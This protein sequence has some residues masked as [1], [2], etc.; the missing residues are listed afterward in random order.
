MQGNRA[1]N[2]ET[3]W[4]RSAA[5]A[6]AGARVPN[7]RVAQPVR[8]AIDAPNLRAAIDFLRKAFRSDM[9]TQASDVPTAAKGLGRWRPGRYL[10]SCGITS[11]LFLILASISLAVILAMS[12]SARISFARG[13]IGY[14]NEQGLARIDSLA[15]ELAIEFAKHGGWEFL[16]GRPRAW[17][18]LLRPPRPAAPPT[19][20]TP[21]PPLPEAE[22]IGVTQRLALLDVQKRYVIGNPEINAA[23]PMRP[24]LA[25]GAIVGWLA[26]VP[27]QQAMAAA[28]IRFQ[29]RQLTSNWIIAASTVTLMA[30]VAL[31][32]SRLLVTPLKRIAMAT[33][34]LARGDYNTRI[35]VG[36]RDEIGGLSED[37]NRLA[38]ALEKNERLR[39]TFMA[40]V[41]HELRTPLAVLRG[42]LEAIEDGVRQMTPQTLAS[43]QSEVATLNKL[44][45]DLYDLSL[46]DVGALTYRMTEVDVGDLLRL[47]LDA[48]RERLAARGLRVEVR[49]DDPGPILLGDER[50]LQQL[51]NNLLE[52]STRYTDTGGTLRI[53]CRTLKDTV[54]IDVQDSGPGVAPQVLPHLFERFFRAETSRNRDSGG[55]GLGLAICR[56][57]VEAHAGTIAASAA[58]LGGLLIGI[59]LPQ[60]QA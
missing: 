45:S 28:D 52:N 12:I 58:P 38:Q 46:S 16:R 6:C 49:I 19:E 55:A 35:H 36:S 21:M 26:L 41:S 27:F 14:L 18:E 30:L 7:S 9:V 42:E 23:A 48:F 2:M 53:E 22:S 47:T 60:A 54:A 29:R 17:F 33:H 59:R 34:R 11:K 50:R 56:N 51:F 37:F 3:L 32:L 39:R 1:D 13:F 20:G 57:I 8:R 5:V 25:D 4:S 43:L 44:V 31:L 24:I 40:D 10:G 15:P